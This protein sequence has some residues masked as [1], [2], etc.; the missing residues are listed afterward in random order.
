MNYIRIISVISLFILC[1]TLPAN[2]QIDRQRADVSKIANG[3]FWAPALVT[4]PTT[5]HLSGGVLNV[6]VMHSFGIATENTIRNF[7]GLDNV[8]NVR[9]GLDFGI[10][11]RWSLGIGRSS[12]L[13]VVDLR[14]KYALLRQKKANG[15][16]FSLSL[17]GNIATITQENNRPAED[18]ISMLASLIISRKFNNTISFQLTPIYTHYNNFL[19][20]EESNFLALGAG[21]EVHLNRRIAFTGEYYP[22]IGNRPAETKNAFSLGLNIKTGGHVFQLFFT[23][24]TWHVGQY[25]ITHNDK[26]FWAGDFRFGFNV[27]RVFGL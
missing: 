2:A 3:A 22:I 5:H 19:L 15:S 9:L 10:T 4:Q 12:L 16:P 23:S 24:T 14:T 17:E 26:Q 13:N 8:Q 25:I 11:N 20:G 27:N 6:T 21:A 7:F 1:S 18:D